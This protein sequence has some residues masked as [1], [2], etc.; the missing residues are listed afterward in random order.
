V[1]AELEGPEETTATENQNDAETT[2]KATQDQATTPT[3][4]S[5]KVIS[6]SQQ[7]DKTT[8]NMFDDS[9]IQHQ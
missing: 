2:N 9:R 1:H 4:L 6:E 8:E 5:M 7:E 3:E